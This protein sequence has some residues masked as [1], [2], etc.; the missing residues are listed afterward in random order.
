MKVQGTVNIVSNVSHVDCKSME[1]A[2]CNRTHAK[3]S[4]LSAMMHSRPSTG[5]R[6]VPRLAQVST[7]VKPPLTAIS[8]TIILLVSMEYF[9]NIR[10]W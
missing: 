7:K 1:G 8:Y 10:F 9:L 5:V 3:N 2:L 4:D 6:E